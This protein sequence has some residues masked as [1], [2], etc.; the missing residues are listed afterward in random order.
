MFFGEH[1]WQFQDRDRRLVLVVPGAEQRSIG[2]V[3]S[4]PDHG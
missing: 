3:R 2:I 1:G 4:E